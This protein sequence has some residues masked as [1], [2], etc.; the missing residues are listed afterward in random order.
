MTFDENFALKVKRKRKKLKLSQPAI[1][2]LLYVHPNTYR[3]R[4][5]GAT[6]WTAWEFARLCDIFHWDIKRIS[7]DCM[8]EEDS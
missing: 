7:K 3:S 8:K 5:S 6:E 2:R 1:A 4:E